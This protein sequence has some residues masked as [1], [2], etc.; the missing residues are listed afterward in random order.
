MQSR[1]DQVQAYFYVVGRMTSAVTHGRPDVV[2]PPGR[3]LST[4]LAIGVLIAAVL[5]A[6][7]GVYGLFQ[8][9]GNTSW[10][11][12]GALVT[13]KTSGARFVYLNGTLHPVLNLASARLASGSAA[14]PTSVSAASLA[15]TP[16]GAPI[17]IPDA[18]DS[19]PAPPR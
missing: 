5:C 13:E 4:G 15:G 8:P 16:V 6:G 9:G 3:R 12:A 1:R 7:F 14:A 2:R 18:P 17:G 19:P 10:R 11:T